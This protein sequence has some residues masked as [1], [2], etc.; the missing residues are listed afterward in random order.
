MPF[1]CL[2]TNNENKVR[3]LKR[4]LGDHFE[5]YYHIS[6]KESPEESGDSYEENAIIKANHGLRSGLATIADDSGLEVYALSGQ[7]GVYS[8]RYAGENRIEKLL[9]AIKDFHGTERGA[10]FISVIAFA[11]WELGAI[12]F[13]HEVSGYIYDFPKGK[14]GFGFDPI[15]IPYGS[16]QTFAEMSDEQKDEFSHRGGAVRKFLRWTNESPFANKYLF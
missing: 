7:P 3:E 16:S 13:R 12:T 1:I 11:H 4:L 15:F 9:T 14:N 10:K 6:G 5:G 2:G 8:A